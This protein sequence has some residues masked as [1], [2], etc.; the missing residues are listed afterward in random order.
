ME[1]IIQGSPGVGFEGWRKRKNKLIMKRFPPP[2]IEVCPGSPSQRHYYQLNSD[3]FG[4]CY[5]CKKQKDFK[6]KASPESYYF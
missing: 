3:S 1:D 4:V 5:Y 6:L 2:V